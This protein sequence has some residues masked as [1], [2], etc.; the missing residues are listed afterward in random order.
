MSVRGGERREEDEA[1]RVGGA[2]IRPVEKLSGASDLALKPKEA[3][4]PASVRIR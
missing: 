1:Q 4:V 3:P 2:D